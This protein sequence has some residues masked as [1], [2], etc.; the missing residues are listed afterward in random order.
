MGQQI[1]I[2]VVGCGHL[3]QKGLIEHLSQADF[4]EK[5]EIVALCD[6]VVERAKVLAE[7]YG[8]SHYCASLSEMLKNFDIDAVLVLTP[9]Q[10]HYEH[11]MQSLRVNK[12]VYVQKTMALNFQQAKE[13][14]KEAKRRELTLAAAPGQMLSPA[15]EQMKKIIEDGGI[16]SLMWCYAGTTCGNAIETVNA[17]GIDGS[18][19]YLYGGGPL[20]NTTVYSLHALTGIVGTVSKV[21]AMMK[22]ILAERLRKGVPFQVTEKDNALLTLEFETG[23]LGHSW[24]CR[25]ATGSVLEWGSIGFYGTEGSLET[26][27]IHHPSGW[28]SRIQWT[29]HGKMRIFHYPF[30][31]FIKGEGWETPLAPQ[32]HG[33]ILEPHVYMDVLD[34]VNSIRENRAPI[35]SAEQAAHVVEVIEKAYLADKTQ[36]M[37]EVLSGKK[38]A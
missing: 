10:Q 18:W 36:Q 15:L 11:T 13:M 25:S 17:D 30:G 31:G 21:N 34:F 2:G 1:N 35:P 24:G 9:I 16:G 12:H 32:P 8:I 33:Q 6:S 7:K 29:H 4:L 5:A 19:Q 22:T 23:V 37:Q 28:P 38:S 20:W 14:V 3:A 27:S 26:T